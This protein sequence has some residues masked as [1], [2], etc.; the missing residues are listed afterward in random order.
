M[1]QFVD[2]DLALATINEITARY[3]QTITVFN[4]FGVDA[5]C[6]GDATLAEAAA[7][8]GVN[9]DALNAAIRSAVAGVDIAARS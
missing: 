2:L 9:L 6:G 4:D 3:P 1:K 8:D 7:R 5:C